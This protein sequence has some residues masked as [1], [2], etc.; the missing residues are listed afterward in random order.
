MLRCCS[1]QLQIDQLLRADPEHDQAIPD[2]QVSRG[3]LTSLDRL[4]AF[5]FP[6]SW[7][8]SS[9]QLQPASFQTRRAR[10]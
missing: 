2:H 8:S 7:V 4:A 9:G 5:P 10:S 1:C 6:L 3:E